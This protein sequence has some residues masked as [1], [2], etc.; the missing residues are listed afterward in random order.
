[1]RYVVALPLLPPVPLGSRVH[2]PPPPSDL[3]L[4]DVACNGGRR[5][6]LTFPSRSSGEWR[7]ASGTT[8]AA[9]AIASDLGR[10]GLF[11]AFSYYDRFNGNVNNFLGFPF[12]TSDGRHTI[13]RPLICMPC[14]RPHRR[15]FSMSKLFIDFERDTL[16]NSRHD[17][18]DG[19]DGEFRR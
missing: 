6:S 3:G 2:T 16:N 15:R 1:M 14:V 17:D 19:D 7:R 8:I 13:V 5:A 9:A 10:L 11:R 4:C 12:L 18:D